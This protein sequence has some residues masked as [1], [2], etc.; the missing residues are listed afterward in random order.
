MLEIMIDNCY[1]CDR[2]T[3]NDPNNSQCFWLN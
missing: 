2:E 3:I 1:R